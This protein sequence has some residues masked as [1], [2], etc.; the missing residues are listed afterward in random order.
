MVPMGWV[1]NG[2]YY[3]SGF[4]SNGALVAYFDTPASN[5]S[6]AP[7]SGKGSVVGIQYGGSI[8]PRTGSLS[9]TACDFTGGIVV[10]G[11]HTNVFG[12]QDS[13]TVYF[14]F[15]YA[16]NGY[17]ELAPGTRYY[18]N[19]YNSSGCSPS[20]SICG[21][22]SPSRA[23]LMRGSA[24]PRFA[25]GSPASAGLFVARA[26]S[27]SFRSA[28]SPAPPRRN[29]FRFWDYKPLR[30]LMQHI[31]SAFLIAVLLVVTDCVAQT[32][33]TPNE[34][35]LEN[36]YIKLTRADYELELLRV[37]EE[38]RAEFAANPKRLT[39]LLNQVLV[40]KTLAQQ[41]RDEGLDRDPELS[42]RLAHE[43]DRFYAQAEVAKIEADAGADFDAHASDY[44]AKAREMYLLDKAKSGFPRRSAL[45]IFCSKSAS[46]V[47][48]LRCAAAK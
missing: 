17:P 19:M 33:A 31:A 26:P 2:L 10:N 35:L 37:P 5:P 12:M 11:T 24:Q 4:V 45:R 3:S 15:G 48:Q 1:A 28:R 18:L 41:A 43:L 6:P 23:G 14:T 16:K 29:S 20:E 32:Q 40:N 25:A 9:A 30:G 21:L 8:E 34:V 13:P 46:A 36:K 39:T 27:W 7:S 47:M 44:L 22:R 38:M 42:A